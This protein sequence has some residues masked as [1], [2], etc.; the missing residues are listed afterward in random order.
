[1]CLICLFGLRNLKKCHPDYSCSASPGQTK[2]FL[3]GPVETLSKKLLS[4]LFAVSLLGY[5]ALLVWGVRRLDQ[6]TL[7][8]NTMGKGSRSLC[9][10][11]DS[12]ARWSKKGH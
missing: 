10:P 9:E 3:A 5:L 4:S 6:R 8:S 11:H 1:M 12:Q 7:S 2:L